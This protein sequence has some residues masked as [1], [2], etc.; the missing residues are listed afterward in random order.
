MK[1]KELKIQAKYTIILNSGTAE[2]FIEN[3]EEVESSQNKIITLFFS[4]NY[5][6]YKK[7]KILCIEEFNNYSKHGKFI[8]RENRISIA[9]G[10]I[11]K[12]LY[13]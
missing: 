8:L 4:K 1:N 11:E 3:I 9:I 2:V 7:Q 5:G 12:I 6:N 13:S 10:T